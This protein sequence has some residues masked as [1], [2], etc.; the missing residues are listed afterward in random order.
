[1]KQ[2]K[3]MSVRIGIMVI[4]LMLAFLLPTVVRAADEAEVTKVINVKTKIHM[5]PTEQRMLT[6]QNTNYV[7]FVSEDPSIVTI[8]GYGQ[9]KGIKAGETKVSMTVNGVKTVYDVVIGD[10]VDIIVFAGQS[11]MAGAGGDYIAAPIPTKGTAYEYNLAQGDDRKLLPMQEPF[12]NG[13]NRARMVNGKYMSGNGTLCSSFAKAYYKYTKVPIVGIPAAWGGTTTKHWLKEGMLT[14]TCKRLKNAKKYLKKNGIKVRHIYVLWY[15]GESD[16]MYK[17]SGDT[18]I[19]NM[20][21]IWKKLKKQGAEKMFVI[22]IADQLGVPGE[23]NT[24]KSAQKKLCKKNKDFILATNAASNM[25]NKLN[26]YADVVHLNQKALNKVGEKA[27]NTA[28]KYAKKH[29]KK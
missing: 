23:S 7:E 12:G 21:K 10:S 15:Q 22:K 1:M 27:G 4:T 6:L 16:A 2:M 28:G 8:N 26:Y 5:L 9:M 17:V 25:S 18:Y 13:V 24:I 11:N 19:K 20:K 14:Q 29:S 3:K